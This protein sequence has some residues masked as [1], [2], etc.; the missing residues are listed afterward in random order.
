[1]EDNNPEL[2]GIGVFG[3]GMTV[4][5]LIPILQKCGFKARALWGKTQQEAA[6]C[7]KDLEI[8]FY[9]TKVIFL[10]LLLLNI[11]PINS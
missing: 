8:D 10:E 7:A 2:P 3:T 9:T 5:C 4:K 11:I 6:E 1:M